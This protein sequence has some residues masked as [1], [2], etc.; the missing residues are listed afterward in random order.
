MTDR[1]SLF[2]EVVI[3]LKPQVWVNLERI[4]LPLEQTVVNQA[5]RSF[6]LLLL[7]ILLLAWL[8]LTVNDDMTAFGN[9]CV[10]VADEP[11][12]LGWPLRLAA[13]MAYGVLSRT[14]LLVR[15]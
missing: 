1:H 5:Y 2:H 15:H 3:D 14:G 9:A 6:R 7:L 11:G 12:R 4:R 10:R 8:L 13:A